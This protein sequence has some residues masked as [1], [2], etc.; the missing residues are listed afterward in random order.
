MG[1]A[2]DR[3]RD[4]GIPCRLLVHG[5][6]GIGSSSLA[7]VF[8]GRRE[9]SFPDGVLYLPVGDGGAGAPMSTSGL[10]R[11]A[12]I[13]LGIPVG[14][15]PDS[16]AD[17]FAVYR[18]LIAGKSLLVIF[19]GVSNGDQIARLVPT[20]DSAVVI[21]TTRRELRTLIA[22]G[23]RPMRVPAL[24]PD[25]SRALLRAM[26]DADFDAIDPAT[27]AALLQT[28]D[29]HPLA[30]RIVGGVLAGQ[31]E[32][33]T[34]LAADVG[35]V[36]ID[37]LEVDGV[38]LLRTVL[39]SVYDSL[40]DTLQVAYRRLAANPGPDFTI[41]AAEVLLAADSA[42]AQR[43]IR[44]L[45]D[46]NLLER[47]ADQRIRFHPLV[48]EHARLKA[49]DEPADELRQRQLTIIE[50]YRD[51]GVA[52]EN[53]VTRRWRESAAYRKLTAAPPFD[54]DTRQQALQ[55]LTDERTNLERAVTIAVEIRADAIAVDLGF[56]LW[57]PFHLF[58]YTQETMD[59]MERGVD[60]ARRLN[61]HRAA[62]QLISQQGYGCFATG[63]HE[64][65][66]RYFAESL[67]LAKQLH[68]GLGQ[69]SALEWL[70]KVAAARARLAADNGDVT[71]ASE[72]LAAALEFY[73][74]SEAI[75]RTP[76]MVPSDDVGRVLALL[77]LH[78]GRLF[79]QHHNFARAAQVLPEA[80][81]HF[82]PTAEGDN[83]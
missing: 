6:A 36:G 32:Y 68:H 10:L 42:T 41:T 75:A 69:Q 40:S 82:Q 12:L 5:A 25:S 19:D 83:Y 34:R 33:A 35:E 30:L 28:C 78:R 61:D 23:W 63:D 39:D 26:L 71:T 16:E 44:S 47:A 37:A 58:G 49:R 76:G 3:M 15:L 48:R 55:W 62:M 24:D 72:Q 31:P 8:A 53:G 60:A 43:T 20:S 54:P 80:V 17:Q 67:A 27:V 18:R 11:S 57:T 45:T 46:A 38:P 59:A 7:A 70:G 1:E 79:N 51:T 81:R 21:A 77:A 74:Q 52:W 9:G 73:R 56:V 22:Q 64:A 2:W 65:A 29:G 4:T 14:E 50:W 66:E 13:Q